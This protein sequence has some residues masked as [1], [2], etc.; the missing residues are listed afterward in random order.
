MNK[1]SLTEADIRSKFI[2][3]AIVGKWDLMTQILEEHYF[4]NGRVIVRGKTTRRGKAKKADYILLYRP[5]L[6]LAIVEA[7]ESAPPNHL[8]MKFPLCLPNQDRIGVNFDQLLAL[9]DKL[10]PSF[11]ELRVC[12]GMEVVVQGL[13]RRRKTSLEMIRAFDNFEA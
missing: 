1:K 13:T 7:K 3:P 6:P 5:N 9:V 10:P 11:E 8:S 2:T 12:T 4:T